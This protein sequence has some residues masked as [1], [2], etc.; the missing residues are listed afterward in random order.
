MRPFRKYKRKFFKWRK[1][2]TNNRLLPFFLSAI[3][4]LVVGLSAILIKTIISY[5]EIY[6][7]FFSPKFLFFILPLI[8]FLTVTFL[9]RNVFY[10]FAY[11]NGVKFVIDAIENKASLINFRLMYSK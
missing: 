6:A 2:H 1:A 7:I 5:I 10:R 8:G 4:G 9:N 11:F 3:V